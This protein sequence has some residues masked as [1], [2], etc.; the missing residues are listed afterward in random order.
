MDLTTVNKTD[1]AYIHIL[2]IVGYLTKWIEA[3]PSKS[4]KTDAVVS[5]FKN[6]IYRL[7]FPKVLI[8]DNGTEFCNKELD[9][10]L[11]FSRFNGPHDFM[12]H[13][14]WHPRFSVNE[15]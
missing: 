8:S 2:I 9:K 6:S 10:F 3:F 1:D 15:F 13:W 7:A 12:I 5:C 11:S 4:K 14:T